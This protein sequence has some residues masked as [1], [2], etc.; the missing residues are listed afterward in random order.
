M[1]ILGWGSYALS[2]ML[3]WRNTLSLALANGA[4]PPSDPAYKMGGGA[5]RPRAPAVPGGCPG[6]FPMVNDAPTPGACQTRSG[7][8][9][10]HSAMA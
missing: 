5:P 4:S 3:Q 9:D 2:P 7:S 8:E 10:V 6:T 1:V